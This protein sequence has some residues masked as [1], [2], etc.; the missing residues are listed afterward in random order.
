MD[1]PRCSGLLLHVT[2]LPSRFGIGDLGPAAYRFADLLAGARQRVWQMLPVGPVGLGHSPYA[3]PSTFAGNPLLLSPDVLRDEG[4]LHADDLAG[5]PAF[6]DDH[7]DFERVAPYKYPLLERAFDRFEA[8]ADDAAHAAF[9]GFCEAHAAWLDD[10]A[11][12]AALRDAH[13]GGWTGW[14]DGLARRDADAL[15]RARE[16]LARPV[17]RHA[18]WQFLF[19][20]QWQAL[21]AHCR[22]RRLHLLGDLPI[23][24][25]HDS[26][27][28]WADPAL[29]HLDEA[30]NPTVVAG[31]PPDYFSA[32]G[33]RWGN[34]LYRW[35]RMQ[36]DG[37]AWWIR[38]IEAALRRFDLL[39]LD[40]FR[41]FAAFWEV[42]AEEETAI[43]GR[44][45]EAPGEALF[46]H[47]ESALGRLPLL[48]ENLGLI[49]DEVTALMAR[50]ALPGMAVLQFG[51]G[52]DAGSEHLPH[53][54][55]PETA[56]YTGT[57]DN[58]TLVGW[59]RLEAEH[60][61][62]QRAYARHYLGLRPEDEQGVHWHG[63]RLLMASVARL[64]VTPVQDVL[65][66]GSDARMNTPGRASGNWTWRLR[67]DAFERLEGEPARRL[68]TLTQ[69]YGR[70]EDRQPPPD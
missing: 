65:G 57:H 67:P 4:L 70:T 24:V 12:F 56:A 43:R 15:A 46:E 27:D 63:I 22:R 55:T 50:F 5:A 6:A 62:R 42:P 40:H 8:H 45:V 47:V 32:T 31:V 53:N 21:R 54:Y 29:F 60:M 25:A 7:V 35:D 30:G 20:R 2:S 44:W 66:L 48:A 34:P 59:W 51:F 10:Y 16:A 33:Q 52:D 13:E 38:R 28:V 61:T 39:R 18:F 69:T 37:F 19:E 68:R 26:A 41:A 64:V 36:R 14:P 49:T 3:S 1:L 11:L 58:D 9:E 17:Q 23:Y